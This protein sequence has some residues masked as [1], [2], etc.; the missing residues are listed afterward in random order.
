MK[1]SEIMR[2]K[3]FLAATEV[4]ERCGVHVSTVYSWIEKG[5]VE[6][7]RIGNRRYVSFAS[8]VKYMGVEQSM[9]LGLIKEGT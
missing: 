9:L 7:E 2:S 1:Q 8:L 4:A 3:G 6:G 5:D